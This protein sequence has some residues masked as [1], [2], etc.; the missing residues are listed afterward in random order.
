MSDHLFRQA[1]LGYVLELPSIFTSFSLERV[2]KSRDGIH[3]DLLV[4]S[5]WPGA[6]TINGVMYG[7]QFNVSAGSTR[8][9]VANIL[10]ERAPVANKDDQLDWYGF[11]EEFCQSIMRAERDGSPIEEIGLLADSTRP[12]ALLAPI[13]DRDQA[14]LLYGDSGTGKS[15]LALAM[16]LSVKTGRMIVP[17]FTPSV[18]GEVLYL[19]YET[20][21]EELDRRLKAICAGASV[22]RTSVL[23]RRCFSPLHEIAENLARECAERDI[24]LIII[25]PIGY[26]MGFQR[27]GGDPSEPALRF[28]GALRLIGGTALG[29]DHI[30]KLN[31]AAVNAPSKPYGSSYKAHAARATWELK[32]ASEPDGQTSHIAVYHQK[33]N[34]TRKFPAMGFAVNA[35][36]DYVSWDA[37]EIYDA[38]L[39]EAM[40]NADRIASVLRTHPLRVREIANQS[41]MSENL[42]RSELNRLRGQKFE[43]VATGDW[44]VIDGGLAG[45]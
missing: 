16:A 20:S 23:Y 32:I 15:M 8:K 25:D 34:N 21:K 18:I 9:S 38:A 29:V 35:S 39:T 30:G 44:K 11:I 37:E 12:P 33:H 43:K 6:K 5:S 4:K 36:D 7:A 3:G 28:F 42:V 10:A 2:S 40:N 45:A 17:G 31:G 24:A 26:A 1:G 19:D 27:D 14:T 22:P 41:G 13:L